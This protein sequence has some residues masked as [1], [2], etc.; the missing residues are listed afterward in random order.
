M[1]QF[2][3]TQRLQIVLQCRYIEI[4]LKT[5]L[6]LEGKSNFV[7]D[8]SLVLWFHINHYSLS[9]ANPANTE[10]SMRTNSCISSHFYEFHLQLLQMAQ[11]SV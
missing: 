11:L 2:V 3:A 1:S 5:D 6:S 7:S 4:Y 9:V 10:V 8:T